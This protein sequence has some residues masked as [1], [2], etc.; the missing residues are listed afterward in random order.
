MFHTSVSSN[1]IIAVIKPESA[2]GSPMLNEDNL[3]GKLICIYLIS[4]YYRIK[5]DMDKMSN[6]IHFT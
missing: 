6:F 1:R 2:D 3:I 5:F 4:K